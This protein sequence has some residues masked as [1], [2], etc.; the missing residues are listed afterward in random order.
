[1]KIIREFLQWRREKKQKKA[2]KGCWFEPYEDHPFT[3]EAKCQS[4]IKGEHF[5]LLTMPTEVALGSLLDAYG[6]RNQPCWPTGK[7]M[8]YDEV[9]MV[10]PQFSPLQHD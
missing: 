1:M 10:Y 8:D 9:S 7:I 3:L 4:V 5:N 6:T 2:L